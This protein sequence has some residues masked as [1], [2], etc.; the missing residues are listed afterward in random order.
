MT[1]SPSAMRPPRPCTGSRTRSAHH[2]KGS[3]VLLN[4][5]SRNISARLQAE[6]A[7]ICTTRIRA[8][9]KRCRTSPL[10]LRSCL[11]ISID[12]GRGTPRIRQPSVS[13]MVD[14]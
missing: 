8:S 12:S 1:S 6:L 2:G 11:Q 7:A 10:H 3:P 9:L 14:A 4:L 5:R 13:G